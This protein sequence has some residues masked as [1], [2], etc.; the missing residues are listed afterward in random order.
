MSD[1]VRVAAAVI[2]RGDGQ[3]LL[4]QRPAGKVYAGYWEFPGG[5]LEAGETAYAALVRELHE[6]L[7]LRVTRAYPWL[8]RH[9]V[10]P[11]A[12]VELNF[13]RVLAWQGEPHPHEGQSFSWQRAQAP[14]VTPLLPANAPILRALQLPDTYAITMAAELGL[15]AFLQRAEHALRDGLR[16]IQLREKDWSSKE[17]LRL[18]AALK[19]LAQAHGAKILLNGTVDEARALQLDGVHW[20][21]MRLCDARARPSDMLCAASC[22]DRHE[23]AQAARLDL[24]FVVLGPIAATPT[25]AHAA[26]MGWHKFAELIGG[27]ELPVYALG[28]LGRGDLPRALA[29]GAHG[30]AMRRGAW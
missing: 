30:I 18:A 8:T 26:P 13:F 3:F 15:E 1:V 2:V 24:D 23:L 20:T 16:L 19:E 25:H 10:Y 27:Y 14:T 17:R 4:A 28:G 6:E 11:H 29:A 5:K 12:K 21:S 7:G 9:Y 22:H